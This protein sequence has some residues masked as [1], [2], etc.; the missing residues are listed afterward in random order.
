V[1]ERRRKESPRERFGIMAAEK[2]GKVSSTLLGWPEYVDAAAKTFL[3]PELNATG[4]VS[5]DREGQRYHIKVDSLPGKTTQ[6][7]RENNYRMLVHKGET[8]LELSYLS[9]IARGERTIKG[10][11]IELQAGDDR[12]LDQDAH[13]RSLQLFPEFFAIPDS[14]VEIFPQPTS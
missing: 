8:T 13:S 12:L 1:V 2:A 6:A 9:V 14:A 5:F 10:G 11:H 4:I 3:D 7:G